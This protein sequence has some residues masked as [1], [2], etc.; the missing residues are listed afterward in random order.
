MKI[1]IEIE[2]FVPESSYCWGCKYLVPIYESK[3]KHECTIFKTIR[4]TKTLKKL[5]K[6]NEAEIVS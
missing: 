5:K 6:C 4:D 3:T 2:I 1:K